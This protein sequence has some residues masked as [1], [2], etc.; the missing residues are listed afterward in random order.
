MLTTIAT[1]STTSTIVA[2]KAVVGATAGIGTGVVTATDRARTVTAR[3]AS[4]ATV[5]GITRAFSTT[6]H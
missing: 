6:T 4:V 2:I 1:G 3:V 5:A